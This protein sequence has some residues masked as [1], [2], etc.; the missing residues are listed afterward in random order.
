[1]KSSQSVT[2]ELPV[3]GTGPEYAGAIALAIADANCHGDLAGAAAL[4]GLMSAIKL[5]AS[6]TSHN[7]Q[8]E[9]GPWL[10]DLERQRVL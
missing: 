10:V 1:M 7:P 8:V 2:L 9:L 4:A 6:R 5:P 3:R